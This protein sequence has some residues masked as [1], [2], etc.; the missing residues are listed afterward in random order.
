MVFRDF[1]RFSNG[2]QRFS[3]MRLPLFPKIPENPM[4]IPEKPSKSLQ[5]SENLWGWNEGEAK[6][7][8]TGGKTLLQSRKNDL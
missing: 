6:K 7:G 2:F 1:P 3:E 5:I 8:G 4:K